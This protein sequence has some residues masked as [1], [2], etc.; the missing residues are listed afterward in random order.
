MMIMLAP[1]EL[2]RRPEMLQSAAMQRIEDL[3]YDW[4][5]KDGGFQLQKP[6]EFDDETLRDGPRHRA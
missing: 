6:L 1:V 4:N 5:S 3:I 2:G